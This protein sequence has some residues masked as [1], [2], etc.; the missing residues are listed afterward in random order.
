MHDWHSLT[1][2][3]RRGGRRDR[4]LHRPDRPPPQFPVRRAHLHLILVGGGDLGIHV[5]SLTLRLHLVALLVRISSRSFSGGSSRG[6]AAGY[7]RSGDGLG[8]SSWFD[9]GCR[10][11]IDGIRGRN[12]GSRRDRRLGASLF[13]TLLHEARRCVRLILA[14]KLSDGI[15]ASHPAAQLR[16]LPA[17]VLGIVAP[18]TPPCR[19]P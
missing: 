13:H 10:R 14:A 8:G 6:W 4:W 11:G 17:L 5:R 15:H 1:C 19:C 16:Q 9:G 12:G 18:R 7:D 2:R 3:L